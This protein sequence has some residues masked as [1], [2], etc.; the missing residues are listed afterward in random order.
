MKDDCVIH[1]RNAEFGGGAIVI[2]WCFVEPK[3]QPLVYPVSE[4]EVEDHDHVQEGH[5]GGEHKRHIGASND[6]SE[7]EV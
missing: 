7:S 2:D 1:Q 3:D 6:L 5:R 4:A